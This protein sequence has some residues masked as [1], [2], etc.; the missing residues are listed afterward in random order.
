MQGIE[1]SRRFYA[2]IVR[3]WLTTTAAD[4][5]HAA[6]LIGYGSELLG[7]DDE[8]SRDHNWGPRVHL[9]VT[10]DDFATHARRLVDAFTTMAPKTYLGEPIGWRSRPHPA[11]SGPGS[12]GAIDHGLEIHTLE[13]RLDAHFA[14]P[15]VDTLTPLQWLGFAEQKLL[16]FTAG[17]VFHDDDGRLTRARE[18]LAYFPHDIWLYKLACQWRR[19]AE[20]QAF[21]GRAGQVGDDLGSRII[22]ARLARDIMRMGFLLERR[23]APYAKWLGSAFERLPIAARLTPH[24]Q[25]ALSVTEWQPRGEAL[26][27]AYLELAHTQNRLG[28]ASFEPVIGPY[29]ERPFATLNVDDAIAALMGAITDPIVKSLPILGSFDQVIDSTPVAEDA[30]LSHKIMRQVLC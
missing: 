23:Y 28:I 13:A 16:A 21:V 18:R 3:P 17:A 27:A 12:L 14:T 6:A 8:T 2:D 7:F 10:A 9:I 4:L 15:S 5:S 25:S 19:I 24:L 30:D 11:A 26:A 1:L 29:H 22:A 20:E